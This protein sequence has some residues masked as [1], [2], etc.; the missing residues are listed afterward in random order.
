MFTKVDGRGNNGHKR[1]LD[2]LNHALSKSHEIAGLIYDGWS[3]HLAAKKFGVSWLKFGPYLRELPEIK[4]AHNWYMIK[5]R[6]API[7]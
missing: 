5:N 6:R 7:C 3:F 4:D 1:H 2:Y